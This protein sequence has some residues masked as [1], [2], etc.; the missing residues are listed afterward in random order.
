MKRRG[1]WWQR[2]FLVFSHPSST[3]NGTV[4][5]ADSWVEAGCLTRRSAERLAKQGNE[6]ARHRGWGYHVVKRADWEN[7]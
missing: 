4:I 7:R 3:P 2:W 1:A 6:S 5:D